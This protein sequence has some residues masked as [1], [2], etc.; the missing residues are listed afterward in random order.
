MVVVLP[1]TSILSGVS[2][3]FGGVIRFGIGTV[4][5]FG[6]AANSGMEQTPPLDGFSEVKTR[7]ASFTSGTGKSVFGGVAFNG[8]VALNAP[9]R[10]WFCSAGF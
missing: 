9:P 4:A 10:L 6:L 8:G 5:A 1:G 3:A 2:D 7:G